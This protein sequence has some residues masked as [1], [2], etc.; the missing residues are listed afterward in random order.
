[1]IPIKILCGCGQKYAFDVEPSEGGVG[2]A[3]QCPACGADGSEAAN[4]LIAEQ[5]AT[6]P[7]G[8][9]V[10]RH[11]AV[12]TTQRQNVDPPLAPPLS[13]YA[14]PARARKGWI[15]PAIIGGG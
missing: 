7:A 8:L 12:A 3:V 10:R 5:T 2:C 1:M 13:S 15:V 9:Q 14:A 11:P 4:Q 6:R